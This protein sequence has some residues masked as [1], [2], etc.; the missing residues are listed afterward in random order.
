MGITIDGQLKGTNQHFN[1][2][3]W[4]KKKSNTTHSKEIYEKNWTKAIRVTSKSQNSEI[5]IF[6]TIIGSNKSL[7]YSR[8]LKI[9]YFSL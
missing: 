7:K 5:A 9:F 2:F 1:F 4:Q 6:K 8:I 3:R